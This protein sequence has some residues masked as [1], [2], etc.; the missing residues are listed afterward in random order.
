MGHPLP[1]G[2]PLLY[3][4]IPGHDNKTLGENLKDDASRRVSRFVG[5]CLFSLFFFAGIIGW[6]L[7]TV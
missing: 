7:L 4:L 2:S 6:A 5:G 1:G 3:P